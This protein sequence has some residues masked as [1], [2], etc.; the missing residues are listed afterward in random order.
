MVVSTAIHELSFVLRK[1][2]GERM[3]LKCEDWRKVEK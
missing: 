2:R 3:K 1:G